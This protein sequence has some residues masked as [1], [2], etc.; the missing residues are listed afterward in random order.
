MADIS[1]RSTVRNNVPITLNN[2]GGES[3]GGECNTTV[4]EESATPVIKNSSSTVRSISISAV[5]SISISIISITATTVQQFMP[6]IQTTGILEN[7]EDN[8]S[9]NANDDTSK[10]ALL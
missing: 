9:V 8:E 1:Q 6:P 3:M 7:Q 10:E 2:N 5:R 4:E